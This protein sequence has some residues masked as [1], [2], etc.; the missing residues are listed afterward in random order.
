M[1]RPAE[2]FASTYRNSTS[3]APSAASA[4]RNANDARANF[5]ARWPRGNSFRLQASSPAV[6]KKATPLM[7]R[8]VNSMM[9]ETAGA[10]GITSPLQSGQWLPQP[11]PDPL[12]RT[13]TPHNTTR[14]FHASTPQA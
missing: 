4:I 7:P 3:P 14:R 8:C 10:L 12:A 1:A 9:V 11:A 2:A 13:S 6:A 5:R